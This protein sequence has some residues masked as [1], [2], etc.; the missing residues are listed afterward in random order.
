LKVIAVCNKELTVTALHRK[1]VICQNRLRINDIHLRIPLST[2]YQTKISKNQIQ[3]ISSATHHKRKTK[4]STA[5]K[6]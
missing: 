2:K 5:N 6:Y 4:K 1:T 3:K